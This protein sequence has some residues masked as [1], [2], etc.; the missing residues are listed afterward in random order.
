MRILAFLFVAFACFAQQWTRH[1]DP[2]GFTV[3]H[4]PG[5]RVSADPSGLVRVASP[6][7][8][9]FAVVQPFLLERPATA[10][11][12]LSL[13]LNQFSGVFPQGRLT[14]I[15]QRPGRSDEVVATVVY[16]GGQASVLCALAGRAGMFYA[17]AAPQAQFPAR[18]AEL[19]RV[20][21][22][23]RYTQPAAAARPASGPRLDYVRWQDPK[24]NAFS[25]E[26]P[27]GW[28]VTGG[29]F[30]FA[31]VDAR[32]AVELTSPDGQIR[33]TS[34][35]AEIPTHTVP[36]QTLAMTGFREGSWYSP[37]YGVR[38]MVRRY[39]PGVNYASEYVQRKIGAG[40]PGV[41]ILDARDRPDLARQ[42]GQ[43]YSQSGLVSQQLSVGE[44]AFTCGGSMRGAFLAGTL[45]T[46]TQGIG[47]WQVQH[48]VGY[49]APANRVAEAEAVLRHLIE[50]AQ[51]NPQ[52]AQMQQGV[53]AASSRIVARTHAEISASMSES[54][55]SRQRSQDNLSRQWS[56]VTLGQTD[57]VDP[58]TGEKWKVASGNNYYW[59]KEGTGQVAG[60]DTWT[61]PDI[62]FTPL[63]EW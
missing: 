50:S 5:W 60:T 61:R 26:V 15:E 57:V 32:G 14:R 13:S 19:V 45:L 54:Y 16:A 44:A 22:S 28:S 11:A 9:A 30:R 7:G 33:I 18:R 41:R 38:M 27:R 3:D 36:T 35:D 53:T 58:V 49:V 8:A 24:E 29:M 59:R 51:V 63:K 21:A 55:W 43:V 42:L 10:R 4:P 37:G 34:G 39:V 17:I 31:P 62:D 52:W 47:I 2:L 56:N 25:I 48:L 40:C 20:L 12:W 46:G 1:N 6:D 23:F